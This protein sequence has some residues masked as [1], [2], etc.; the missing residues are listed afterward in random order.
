MSDRIMPIQ[1]TLKREDVIL[2]VSLVVVFLDSPSPTTS[3]SVITFHFLD[4]QRLTDDLDPKAGKLVLRPVT[5]EDINS[6][7]RGDSSLSLHP[8]LTF[9]H[10]ER[11]ARETLKRV[12]LDR[13]KRLGLFMIG[14]ILV[15]HMAKGAVKKIPLLGGP[16][17]AFTNVL[18]PTT[19]VGPAV[20]VAGA[21]YL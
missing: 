2:Y 19:L 8:L 5:Q 20:G 3:S 15:V 1:F 13:G 9:H 6:A 17:S 4:V 18:V 21:L 16:I 10:F 11:F 14:G 7:V 12:A